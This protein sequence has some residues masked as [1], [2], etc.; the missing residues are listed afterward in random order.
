MAR[1]RERLR[2]E[3][4]RGRE[5]EGERLRWASGQEKVRGRGEA[6]CAGVVVM[7]SLLR[8]E[9]ARVGKR[10][11]EGQWE[12]LPAG[13]GRGRALRCR[14]VVGEPAVFW[15]LVPADPHY[16]YLRPVMGTYPCTSLC[17]FGS[18]TCEVAGQRVDEHKLQEHANPHPRGGEDERCVCELA[19]AMCNTRTRLQCQD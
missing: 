3:V 4:A 14:H 8:L 19:R 10:W 9:W 1:G 13:E 7:L 12:R 2:G 17:A 5:A 16:P 15:Q 6:S 18:M 11:R